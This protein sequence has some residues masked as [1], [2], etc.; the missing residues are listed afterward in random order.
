LSQR[1]PRAPRRHGLSGHQL[2]LA[3]RLADQQVESGLSTV[4][5]GPLHGSAST[6]GQGA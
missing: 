3:Q 2:D 1:G 4:P 5:A 6:V